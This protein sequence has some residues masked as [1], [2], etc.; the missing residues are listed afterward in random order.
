M[1]SYVDVVGTS[2]YADNVKVN[3][4]RELAAAIKSARQ[5]RGWTQAELASRAG[6]TRQWIIAVERGK[7]TA[8]V[9]AVLRTITALG[10][11]ADIVDAPVG[12]SGFDLDAL[13][14]DVG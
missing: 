2:A 11:V 10:L 7:P 8:E 9:G 14:G 4:V 1:S 6:V 12:H 13:V 5:A 3:S